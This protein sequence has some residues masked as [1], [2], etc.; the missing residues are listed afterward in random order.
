MEETVMDQGE[1]WNRSMNEGKNTTK[2][3]SRELLQSTLSDWAL[4]Y[5]RTLSES[6]VEQWLKIFERY[7]VQLLS[8]ALGYVTENSERMPAPGHLTKAV[9]LMYERHPELVNHDKLVG[10]EGKDANGIACLYWSDET[11]VPAYKAKDCAE[12]RAFLAKLAEFRAN[13]LVA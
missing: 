6:E 8:L 4:L 12:G 10:Y 13:K 5:G 9:I 11:M 3:S 7:Q 1:A 2:K